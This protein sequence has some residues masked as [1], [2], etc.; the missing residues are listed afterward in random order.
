MD[1]ESWR[2]WQPAT[3]LSRGGAAAGEGEEEG[4][5]GGRETA[6]ELGVVDD[7]G[8]PRTPRSLEL[9]TVCA[10]VGRSGN[11]GGYFQLMVLTYS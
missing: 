8:S 11:L 10:L 2:G 5:R 7:R 9:H 1:G 3:E 6:H 4:E